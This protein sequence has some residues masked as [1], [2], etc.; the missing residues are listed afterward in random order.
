MSAKNDIFT[1]SWCDIVFED[2]NKDYGAYPLRKGYERNILVAII[3]SVVVFLVA[4]SLPLIIELIKGALPKEVK[5][6]QTEVTIVDP[7]SI[8]K[9][10][11]PPPPVEPPPPLKS[12]I[13][14]TPPVVVKDEEANDEP[15]PPVEK[16]AEV[17]PGVKTE[18]GDPNGVDLGINDVIGDAPAQIFTIVEQMPSFPGGEEELFK[19][20]S[21]NIH[22][23]VIAKENNISGK[24]FV[25]FVID[26][27]GAVNDVKVLRGIGGGCDEEAIRVVKAMPPWKAGKQNGRSVSVQYNL[28]IFFNL[29]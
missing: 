23:P 14:F 2:R 29:K 19:Y 6:K 17:D 26:D 5:V 1:T 27:K 8:D 21:K 18:E 15:P 10:T 16:L 13:K 20:L 9:T 28:P 3:F 4:L 11:P 7:P 24:V 12:T 25:T 22:Y